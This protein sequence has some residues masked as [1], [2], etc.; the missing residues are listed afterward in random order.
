[1]VELA[2]KGDRVQVKAGR[3][4]FSLST[5]P[6]AD[7]PASDAISTE[8][9][10]DFSRVELRQ[11]IELTHFAMAQQDVR[12]YLNGLLLEIGDGKVRAVAT[13]GHRL[14][15][16]DLVVE[17][18]VDNGSRQ[19]IVPRKAAGEMLRL[20]TGD[21]V[22][23]LSVASNLLRLDIGTVRLTS[24]L[25]DGRFPD[26]NRVIPEAERCDKR[27]E[28]N[29]D[30]LKEILKRTAILSNDK[31]RAIRLMLEKN[32]VRVVASN[33]EQE[34]AED[35]IEVEYEGEEIE[36][37]FN[38]S[39]LIEALGAVPSETVDLFFTDSGSSC[40]IRPIPRSAL[41]CE[42][43]VMPLRL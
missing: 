3:G 7:F 41:D 21:G 2:L 12:Y 42:F 23:R 32:L 14:A 43:V 1:M 36:I 31:Y 26:Y 24:K 22:A 25:I 11:V 27:L 6:A 20:L 38:V 40:L 19:I 17:K 35:C 8:V 18:L 15:L 29:R 10:V 9:E 33:P 34:E 4:R 5:L 13:D 30:E 39:Y 28:V 16:C 37:G